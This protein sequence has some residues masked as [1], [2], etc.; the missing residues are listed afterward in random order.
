MSSQTFNTADLPAAIRNLVKLTGLRP[1]VVEIEFQSGPTSL[2][3]GW[4][5]EVVAGDSLLQS[6]EV[7]SWTGSDGE[8][9]STTT[10]IYT[11][12]VAFARK[13]LGKR[14][15]STVRVVLGNLGDLCPKQAERS[16]MGDRQSAGVSVDL[17]AVLWDRSTENRPEP[18]A[19]V[20]EIS[21][22][23]PGPFNELT[24]R[25]ETGRR[26]ILARSHSTPA[27]REAL[28]TFAANTADERSAALA[29]RPSARL[30]E[31]AHM[32]AMAQLG[33]D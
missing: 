3:Y 29:S 24:E 20:F 11:G 9:N 27:S 12:P 21:V 33:I 26:M 18:V 8:S 31:N 4:R 22:C 25:T 13:G 23:E 10:E 17:L 15:P 7:A 28:A 30:V 5:G 19:E 32:S 16:R 2:R 6:R 1:K 14:D